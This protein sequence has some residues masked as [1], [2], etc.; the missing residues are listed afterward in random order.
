M[1]TMK[2]GIGP[3]T[4]YSWI[5]KSSSPPSTIDLTLQDPVSF[6]RDVCECANQSATLDEFY[7][8]LEERKA[9]RIDE[10]KEGWREVA[11]HLT[12][13]P[14]LL[15]SEPG[16]DSM[17]HKIQPGTLNDSPDGRWSAFTLFS[18]TKSF[19][20]LV[21][22]FDGF[23]RDER[24]KR[25]EQRHRQ[26]ERS[27][28]IR[29]ECEAEAE[30]ARL[31]GK[32][33]SPS[34][35]MWYWEQCQAEAKAK[36]EAAASLQTTENST[37]RKREVD[38]DAHE[39]QRKRRRVMSEGT[40]GGVMRRAL[41]GRTHRTPQSLQRPRQLLRQPRNAK[42]RTILRMEQEISGLI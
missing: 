6:H 41:L 21:R 27:A 14:W 28:R 24:K 16:Y 15:F 32:Q 20:S 18:R 11:V 30:A 29:T 12:S 7:S 25:D 22:L 1:E 23:V 10:L 8:Q 26:K 2:S 3:L 40:G 39:S 5:R 31:A 37:A 9:Q 17:V 4:N 38:E 13:A 19:D 34:P 33:R 42:G 36:A 35:E